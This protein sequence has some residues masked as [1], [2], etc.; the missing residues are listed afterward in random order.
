MEF[1]KFLFPVFF[2]VFRRC[3]TI[4]LLKHSA[5]VF[6]AFQ[7]HKCR[8]RAYWESRFGKQVFC[9]EN[10]LGIDKGR[11]AVTGILFHKS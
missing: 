2:T 1:S 11:K 7:S 4:Y 10:P 5:E 8:N 3:N 6:G 9:F